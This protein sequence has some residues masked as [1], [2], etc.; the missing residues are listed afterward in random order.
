M[1]KHPEPDRETVR[2]RPV[3][4]ITDEMIGKA[5]EFCHD[6]FRWTDKRFSEAQDDD[7]RLILR[8]LFKGHDFALKLRK[9]H[10]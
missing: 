4:K 9:P 5:V 6:Q 10:D 7:L 2:D 3:L 1:T 8:N